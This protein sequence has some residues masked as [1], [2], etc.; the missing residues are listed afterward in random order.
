MKSA[1]VSPSICHEMTGPDAL[2]WGKGE[3]FGT[4]AKT[5]E[6]VPGDTREE[7]EEAPLWS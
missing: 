4:Q 5:G 3:E 7:E 1:T 6:R 2:G